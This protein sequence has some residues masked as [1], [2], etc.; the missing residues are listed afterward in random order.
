[1]Q[2]TVTLSLKTNTYQFL[3]LKTLTGFDQRYHC[4]P[5]LKGIRSPLIPPST[6]KYPAGFTVEGII[7]PAEPYVYFCGVVPPAKGIADNLHVLMIRDEASTI[8][9]EDANVSLLVTGMRRLPILPLPEEAQHILPELLLALSEFPCWM[10]LVPRRSPAIPR[11]SRRR[12][13]A[14]S[15]ILKVES[16]RRKFSMALE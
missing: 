12:S 1:M 10:A 7:E 8:S 6:G 5:G 4:E 15:R 16:T 14:L 9:Y 3:W 11:G 2:P 13:V